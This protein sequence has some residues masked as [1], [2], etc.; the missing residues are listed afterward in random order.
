MVDMSNGTVSW[1]CMSDA[2]V[3]ASIKSA[4]R[5]AGPWTMDDSGDEEIDALWAREDPRDGT[6]VAIIVH[7]LSD[8]IA[9]DGWE[10][11]ILAEGAP[12]GEETFGTVEDAKEKIDSILRKFG[13]RLA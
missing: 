4:P 8:E 12:S 1:S 10:G 9:D 5:C 11:S 6:S 7:N 13:W 3:F 2:D